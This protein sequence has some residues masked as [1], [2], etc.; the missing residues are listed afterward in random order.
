MIRGPCRSGGGAHHLSHLLS[1]DTASSKPAA[2]CALT[3]HPTPRESLPCWSSPLGQSTAF[4]ELPLKQKQKTSRPQ[5][6]QKVHS[7]QRGFPWPLSNASLDSPL[8]PP[9]AWL[10]SREYPPTPAAASSRKIQSQPA[11][12]G[13]LGLGP[14]LLCLGGPLAGRRAPDQV[15]L[16]T[17]QLPDAR[18]QADQPA[19]ATRP[20]A[21]SGPA[22]A[23]SR[24][25][26]QGRGINCLPSH[27]SA[28]E[29]REDAFRREV[30]F[31]VSFLNK[32]KG[33][34]LPRGPGR[35]WAGDWR[36]EAWRGPHG[37]QQPSP[38][39]RRPAA[40]QAGP[41]LGTSAGRCAASRPE[42]RGPGAWRGARA[43]LTGRLGGGGGSSW[44]SGLSPLGRSR[45][46]SPHSSLARPL[47]SSLPARAPR[48]RPL[49]PAPLPSELEPVAAAPGFPQCT[50]RRSPARRPAG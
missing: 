23:E 14:D 47:A 34:G 33:T 22:R 48:A 32:T 49:R 35:A 37:T 36:R 40:R 7:E 8:P 10:H 6:K 21:S 24:Q 2:S 5:S 28:Q 19:S 13:P 42:R 20:P 15:Q 44:V 3:L 30:G 4:P 41:L 16:L 18:A 12:P 45:L 17:Q 29:Q 27:K 46:F 11:T 1:G 25:G 9:Q 43:A 38:A 50:A 39:E 31:R 26:R